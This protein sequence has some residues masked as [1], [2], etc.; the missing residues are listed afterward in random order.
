MTAHRDPQFVVIEQRISAGNDWDG[1]AP[2]TEPV[3]TKG[4]KAFPEDDHGGLF[5]YDFTSF[6]L[7]EIQ[8]IN[9]YFNG[10]AAK[11]VSIRRESGP[12]ILI[13]E[14]TDPAETNILITDKFQLASDE[15][16]VITSNGAATEMYARVIA[17]PLHPEP[18]SVLQI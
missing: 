15:K 12:D 3:F 14:S 10:V 4:I 6:F 5:E 9:V 11:S 17:R 2:S 8:Q 18:T 1:T 7:M 13:F 16:L